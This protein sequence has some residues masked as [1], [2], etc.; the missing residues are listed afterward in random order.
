MPDQLFALRGEIRMVEKPTRLC[1][2]A[3]VKLECTGERFIS[4][5][6]KAKNPDFMGLL[7]TFAAQ[8][9]ARICS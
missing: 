3:C 5:F 2:I 7:M 4:N 6:H 9:S 8:R 1:K